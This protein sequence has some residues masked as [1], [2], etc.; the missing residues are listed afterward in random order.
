LFDAHLTPIAGTNPQQHSVSYQLA[1]EKAIQPLLDEVRSE[2]DALAC[3][4]TT[5]Y[6]Y[7]PTHNSDFSKHPSGDPAVDIRACRDKRVMRDRY[8]QRS[9][10]Y[11]GE[12]L[13]Q[14]FVRDNGE[15]T[16]EIALPIRLDDQHWG[17]VRFGFAP[18]KIAEG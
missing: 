4:C 18:S 11:T 8:G 13:L 10:T 16:V 9:A 7:L 6:G 12:L 3:T 17:A 2:T 5:A 15:L 14:T 1:F